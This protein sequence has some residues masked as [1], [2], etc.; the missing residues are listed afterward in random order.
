MD[1]EAFTL[2]RIGIAFVQM[3]KN[4]VHK[5]IILATRAIALKSIDKRYQY[6]VTD[7]LPKT[8]YPNKMHFQT[9]L[10]YLFYAGRVFIERKLCHRKR[11]N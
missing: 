7:K 8:L 1:K 9:D 2:L 10:S 11:Q 5:I 3:H 6:F 4:Q